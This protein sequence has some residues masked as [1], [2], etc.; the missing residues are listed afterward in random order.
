[1]EVS[2]M[3][4][5]SEKLRPNEDGARR[6]NSGLWMAHYRHIQNG[7]RKATQCGFCTSG[8]AAISSVIESPKPEPD[9][10]PD[11]GIDEERPS[12]FSLDHQW[13]G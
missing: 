5:Q 11:T 7:R 10:V 3:Q 13:P 4:G 2:S 6:L 8:L 1:M 12:P 9:V